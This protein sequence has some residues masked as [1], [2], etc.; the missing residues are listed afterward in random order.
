M[1]SLSR[2]R[3]LIFTI[4]SILA[5]SVVTTQNVLADDVHENISVTPIRIVSP[6]EKEIMARSA[7]H[8]L[9]YIADA[10]SAIAANDIAKARADLQQSLNLIDILKLQQP[11]AKVRDHIWVAKKH[12][13]YESTEEVT[14]DLVLIEADL[15]EIEDFVPVEKARRHIRSARAYLKKGDKA[16]A[17]KE[18]KAA[19]AALIYTEVDL[20]LS[21][22]ERQIVA[23]QKALDNREPAQADKALKQAENGVQILSVAVAAPITRARDSIWQASKNFAARHYAAA[24]AD[25]ARASAWLDKAAQSSDKT[26]REQALKL[27]HSLEKMKRQMNMTAQ[28]TGAGLSRLW[29]RAKALAERESEK[30]LATWHKLH[31]E[32]DA[33]K[34]LMEAKLHLAY[35]ETAQFVQGKSAEVRNELDQAQSYLAKAAKNS[36]KALKAKIHEMGD[37]LK[38]LKASLDDRS[39]KARAR[40]DKLKADLRQ[41]IHDL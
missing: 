23:A 8:V 5:A 3:I 30:A 18:L 34:D 19:D 20:P 4:A 40:Y 27:K 1:E 39:N 33:K 13:D 9:R 21:G 12:L 15:T 14:A 28:G 7:A 17:K 11:T 36:D 25:L 32:S 22:T 29:H 26:T 31:G 24:K 16:G 6:D 38:Q 2:S 37:E 10:R 41:I 35:A